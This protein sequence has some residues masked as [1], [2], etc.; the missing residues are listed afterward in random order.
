MFP[1]APV[2]FSMI[3]DWPHA[4]V[5]FCARSRATTSVAP[6]AAKGTTSFTGFDG[7]ACAAAM[8]GIDERRSVAAMMRRMDF[9]LREYPSTCECE[10][11][12]GEDREECGDGGERL[13]PSAPRQEFE[14]EDAKASG[15]VRGKQDDKHPLARDDQRL[16]GPAQEF[17][18]RALAPNGRSQREEMGRQEER[19]RNAR[20]T[21]NQERP[22]RR[23]VSRVLHAATTANTARSPVAT[24]RAPITNANMPA[25]LA[26][27]RSHSM[28][29]VRRPIEPWIAAAITKRP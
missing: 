9:M 16:L 11:E 25:A 14:R 17:V 15:Q 7:H 13:L 1:P 24:S 12:S 28:A 19:Q 20:Y 6:P 29:I 4:S 8:P 10:C 26:R 23:M 3:T 21:V 22:V 18:Q 27:I 2:R 5:S